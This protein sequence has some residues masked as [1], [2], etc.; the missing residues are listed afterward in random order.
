MPARGCRLT[1]WGCRPRSLA[2]AP[3]K[4]RVRPRRQLREASRA[5]D[6]ERDAALPPRQHRLLFPTGRHLPL[7]EE[8][9]MDLIG[10]DRPCRVS[11]GSPQDG[12][13]DTNGVFV[14]GRHAVSIGL[15][16]RKAESVRQITGR[17]AAYAAP[18]L[19]VAVGTPEAVQRGIDESPRM[20]RWIREDESCRFLVAAHRAVLS[21]LHPR[22][23][24]RALDLDQGALRA[25]DRHD[26]VVADCSPMVAIRPW[27]HETSIAKRRERRIRVRS[28]LAGA[29]P[30][31]HG[32]GHRDA[33]PPADRTKLNQA[34]VEGA[35]VSG[36]QVPQGAVV[37]DTVLVDFDPIGVEELLLVTFAEVPIQAHRRDRQVCPAIT[38]REV[39]EV[40]VAR[41]EPLFGDER[42]GRAR[43][44]VDQDGIVDRGPGPE[45][46]RLPA[47]PDLRRPIAREVVGRDGVDG[48]KSRGD[49]PDRLGPA[50]P[51]FVANR[52]VAG[53]CLGDQPL[54]VTIDTVVDWFGRGMARGN[55]SETYE[56]TLEVDARRRRVPLE[57][58]VAEPE[59][60]ASEFVSPHKF[61]LRD[62][63]QLMRDARD[64]ESVECVQASKMVEVR[65]SHRVDAACF[66]V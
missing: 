44:A 13:R 65:L 10:A 3:G 19:R 53:K 32:G 50:S 26:A 24:D 31:L 40:D 59:G 27:A 64:G 20:T 41:P 34:I 36:L 66:S 12:G 8:G 2:L 5:G 62:T 43:V 11:T 9:Q 61:R 29:G 46:C 45:G 25:R 48:P 30:L 57:E 4:L 54:P 47:N 39:S 60:Q 49:G 56:F 28:N 22:G 52:R 14:S 55:P 16:A 35:I 37:A 51:P 7:D 38:D 15:P 17:T 63:G 21:S 42:V 23:V 1:T 58:S 6:I 33:N 18:K